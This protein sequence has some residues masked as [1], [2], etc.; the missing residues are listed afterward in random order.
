MKL[1]LAMAPTIFL[2]VYSQ[3]VTKW[4]V[5]SLFDAGG[6][7][8][9]EASRVMAY[10]SDPYILSAYAAA[11]AASVAWMFVVERNAISIAFPLYIGLTV[12]LVAIGGMVLQGEPVTLARILSIALILA[13]VAIGSRA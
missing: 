6:E 7:G 12:A 8:R 13:G 3:L 9:G 5:Q 2:M 1:L 4:R 10:L 11:L